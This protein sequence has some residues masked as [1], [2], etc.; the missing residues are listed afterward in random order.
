MSADRITFP[1]LPGVLAPGSCGLDPALYTLEWI[2]GW[3][4]EVEVAGRHFAAA[5]V[6]ALLR[7]VLRDPAAYSVSADEART[8][9]DR[10]LAQA[11]AALEV[12]GGRREW[13]ER[14]FSR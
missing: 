7:E 5:P 14:E 1:S 6:F 10:F 11:G 13:L 2:L 8:A 4:A 3:E 12:A 9:A